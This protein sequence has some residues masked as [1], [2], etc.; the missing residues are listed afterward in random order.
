[1]NEPSAATLHLRGALKQSAVR[2][3]EVLSR[4]GATNPRIFG[5][6]ALGEANAES[7]LDLVVDLTLGQGNELLRVA[8]FTEELSEFLH[9]RLD[10]VTGTLLR[11]KVSAAALADAVPV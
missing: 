10:V 9:V 3:D 5:S 11:Q 1:M 2:I 7:D 6:V 4:Y 8:G